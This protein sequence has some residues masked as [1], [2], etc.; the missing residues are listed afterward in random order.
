VR[1]RYADS[2][3]VQVL[4]PVVQGTCTGTGRSNFKFRSYGSIVVV[5][6]KGC[7][8]NHPIELGICHTSVSKCGRSHRHFSCLLPTTTS[9]VVVEYFSIDCSLYSTSSS[10]TTL[11]SREYSEYSSRA[12]ERVGVGV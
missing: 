11:A 6:V 7:V 3:T 1:E 8:I 10:V 4:V 5:A 12:L 9:R 2:I